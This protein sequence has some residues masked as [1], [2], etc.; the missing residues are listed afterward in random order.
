MTFS[1]KVKRELCILES[2]KT[3]C[4]SSSLLFAVLMFE[5]GRI[6][7]D[8]PEYIKLI[9]NLCKNIFGILPQISV[10]VKNSVPFYRLIIQEN[11][12]N[13]G[14]LLQKKCCK[15]SF[16]KGCFLAS[17]TIIDPSKGNDAEIHFSSRNML[18]YDI[19]T[20]ILRD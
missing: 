3:D 15:L 6:K 14:I 10:A 1:A 20:D 17:G 2:V 16:L 11:L 19:C 9:Y 12:I 13:T 4:C 5:S 18:A 8:F 7:S